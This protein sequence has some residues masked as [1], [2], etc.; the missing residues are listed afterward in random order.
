[1]KKSNMNNNLPEAFPIPEDSIYLD[2]DLELSKRELIVKALKKIL[3]DKNLNLTLGPTLD[4]NNPERSIILNKFDIQIVFTGMISDEIIVPLKNSKIENKGPQLLLAVQVEEELN[5]VHFKGVLKS[6]EFKKIIQNKKIN[7]NEII[8]STDDFKGGI[9]RLFRFVRLLSPESI[10]RAY[11][12]S[13]SPLINI[14]AIKNRLKISSS[15]ITGA[16]LLTFF[17]P[18]LFRPK[19]I[20]GIATL[21]PGS[22]EV[23]SFTRSLT[24]QKK[25]ICLLTPIAQNNANDE[26]EA[27]INIDKPLIYPLKPLNEIQISENENVI[28]SKIAS[29]K[30]KVTGPLNWPIKEIN[31]D[32]SYKISMRPS[33]SGFGS[34]VVINLKI[35]NKK[36]FLI[37][38]EIENKLGN[39][40]RA[41]IKFVDK[42]LENNR[43]TSLSLLLSDKAPDS[44]VLEKAKKEIIENV[45]CE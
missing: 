21:S 22:Y 11:I 5:I 18:Q 26:L 19:L 23:T 12:Q 20:G 39:S 40:K 43:N 24:G 10:D 3:K 15:V 37:T 17:G 45:K 4:L 38:S 25:S 35:D 36:P 2:E 31:K 34:N 14:K 30:N 42:N 44:K 9:D 28:W 41:W 27:L 29:S 7:K 8:L 13:E 32:S 1:M 16:I 6:D 33:G